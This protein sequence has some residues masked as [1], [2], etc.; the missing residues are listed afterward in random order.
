MADKTIK[1]LVRKLTKPTFKSGESDALR[2]N[3]DFGDFDAMETNETAD[4][5]LKKWDSAHK[6]IQQPH[7]SYQK[8]AK[9]PLK[10][11]DSILEDY[12]PTY[13][14]YDKALDYYL[15]T[16]DPSMLEEGEKIVPGIIKDLEENYGGNIFEKSLPR[17]Y[18]VG[19]QLGD[20]IKNK[21]GELV[22]SKYK[23]LS[24]YI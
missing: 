3:V 15:N 18:K 19:S 1:P 2:K 5:F 22:N 4:E 13:E 6:A 23:H 14:D 9:S 17:G 7:Y 20:Y 10:L 24:K 12:A 16:V 11:A 8:G 21:V